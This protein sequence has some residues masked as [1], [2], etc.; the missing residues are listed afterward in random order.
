MY[1]YASERNELHYCCNST[2]KVRICDNNLIKD[3]GIAIKL[4]LVETMFAGTCARE[5]LI[6][7]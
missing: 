1:V 5:M 6:N 7:V 4:L 2:I 3:Y